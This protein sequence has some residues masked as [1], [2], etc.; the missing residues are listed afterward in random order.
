MALHISRWILISTFLAATA[1]AQ[2]FVVGEKTA[3]ADISTDFAPTRVSLPTDKLTERGRR[4]LV[5]NLEAE[6]G[7]AH[8]A[9]P[10]GAGITLQA[11]GQLK[12]GPDQYR[13]LIY[14]KGESSAAGDR[15]VI[16]AVTF[17]P[18]SIILDLNGGPYAKHRFLSHVSFNDA[19]V[20]AQAPA[21]TGSRVTLSFEGGVPEISAPEVKALLEPVLDFGVKTSEEAYADT[22]PAP[23]KDAIAAHD[24]LVGMNHRMVLAALGSPESKVREHDPNDPDGPRFEE[25]IYGHVPQTVRFV[26]FEGDRVSQ[27]KIAAMGKPMEV[28]DQ[29]ELGD[30]LPPP[31]T[32]E[33]ALGDAKPGDTQQGTHTAPPTLRK[34]GDPDPPPNTSGQ[35]QFPTQKQS[36]TAAP[37]PA[38]VPPASTPPSQ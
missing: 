7:F 2:V 14:K 30:Y 8:R 26:R 27:V 1:G 22:L 23:L 10:M 29:N 32:R 17:K 21:A 31:P 38:T 4:D 24:V 13:Q 25:W 35:V 37:I 36:P 28:H 6:Q 12:P 15:I 20:T 33:I 16:T 3:T 34:P 11:N 9:L 5:R 19:P 18:D